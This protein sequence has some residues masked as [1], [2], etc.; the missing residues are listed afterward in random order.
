MSMITVL[1]HAG[2]NVNP[3]SK[4]VK[5][6]YGIPLW[7]QTL[8]Y[9]LLSDESRITGVYNHQQRDGLWNSIFR[10]TNKALNLTSLLWWEPTESRYIPPSKSQ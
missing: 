2:I 5:V 6:I 8:I 9:I 1:I 4:S 7:V 10:L 3:F